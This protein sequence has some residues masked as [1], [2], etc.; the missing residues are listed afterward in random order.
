MDGMNFDPLYQYVVQHK[1][2]GLLVEPLPDMF[3]ELMETYRG[4]DGL[5]FENVAIADRSGLRD[6][7]RVRKEAIDHKLVPHWAKGISTFADDEA[8]NVLGPDLQYQ[9]DRDLILPH[10][11][12]ETVRC[13]TLAN[14][15]SKHKIERIDIFVTDVEGYDYEILRQLD[16]T[17]Y[18]P[19]L[20][21]LEWLNLSESDKDLTIKLL[22]SHGYQTKFIDV[23]LIAWRS[24]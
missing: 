14:L 11:V 20:V 4:I 18:K 5:I 2:R 19:T 22:T 13:E 1:W 21:R 24:S 7:C 8:R 12:K 10:I 17:R 3:V 16:L 15:F 6:M 9:K 23:D